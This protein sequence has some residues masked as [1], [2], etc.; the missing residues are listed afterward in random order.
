MRINRT[1]VACMAVVF[2]GALPAMAAEP[3]APAATGTS[4]AVAAPAQ[5]AELP[6]LTPKP[7]PT[8]AQKPGPCT[9]S[10]PCRF[11]PAISCSGQVVCEWQYDSKWIRGHV[12]CDPNTPNATWLYCPLA[13][14]PG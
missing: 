2:A 5:P 8:A 7:T 14:V 13:P 10:V 9:V 6:W 3:T 4:P 11:G 12:I 1:F